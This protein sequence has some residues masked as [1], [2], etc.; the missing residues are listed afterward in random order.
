MHKA[1]FILLVVG[2]LNWLIYAIFNW[3]IGQIFGDMNNIIAR[4][5]YILVGLS[6]VYE[7]L[8]HKKMC[9]HCNPGGGNMTAPTA[10]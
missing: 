7:L 6:A 10:M 2:G 8:A 3:E 5:I 1:T 9:K 4:I